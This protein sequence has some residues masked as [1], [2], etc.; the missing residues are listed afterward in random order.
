MSKRFKDVQPKCKQ[1]GKIKLSLPNTTKDT[2]KMFQSNN[3]TITSFPMMG[4]VPLT[5]TYSSNMSAP[6][7]KT[8]IL[9]LR[10]SIKSVLVFTQTTHLLILVT[11]LY[12]HQKNAKWIILCLLSLSCLSNATVS[13]CTNFTG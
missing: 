11:A 3:S 6:C 2:F 9:W 7:L 10:N 12:S 13:K 1:A 4:F 8:R 5:M